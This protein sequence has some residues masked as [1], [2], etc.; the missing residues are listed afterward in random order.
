MIASKATGYKQNSKGLVAAED[1]W[2]GFMLGSR[3]VLSADLDPQVA[4]SD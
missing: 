4:Y 1:I 3:E 2:L